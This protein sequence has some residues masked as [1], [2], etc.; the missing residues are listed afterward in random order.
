[1]QQSDQQQHQQHSLQ[2]NTSTSNNTLPQL[3]FDSELQNLAEMGD[4]VDLP[5]VF[6][7]YGDISCMNN[8]EDGSVTPS[9]LDGKQKSSPL[10]DPAAS[11]NGSEQQQQDPASTNN[12]N[13]GSGMQPNPNSGN[14]SASGVDMASMNSYLQ[15][16]GQQPL[17]NNLG[18]FPQFLLNNPNMQSLFAPIKP[19]QTQQ[20][21][22]PNQQQQQQAMQQQQQQQAQSQAQAQQ[23]A[24][25]VN[26]LPRT[27]SNVANGNNQRN[28]NVNAIVNVNA[29][30]SPG[31]NRQQQPTQQQQVQVQQQQQAQ[32]QQAQQQQQQQLQNQM[33]GLPQT[34][35]NPQQLA[36]A[37][38]SNNTQ[39]QNFNTFLQQQMQAQ[40]N[41][42]LQQ[43]LFSNGGL[44]AGN[45][46]ML[47]PHQQMMQ[48]QQ[49]QQ[50]QG[51]QQQ[52]QQTQQQTGQQQAKGSAQSQQEQSQQQQSQQQMYQNQILPL[53]QGGNQV[54]P[55]SG[56]RLQNTSS[57]GMDKP[58]P[59]SKP[60][61]RKKT[62]N[63]KQSY[64]KIPVPMSS[65][66]PTNKRLKANA[67]VS[68]SDTD[69]EHGA[70]KAVAAQPKKPRRPAAATSTPSRSIRAGSIGSIESYELGPAHAGDLYDSSSFSDLKRNEDDMTE[71]ERQLANRKRNREHA[72]NTRAR[73]KAY[74][75]S[76][77]TTL[78]ELC[79][80]RDSLV[81][82]RAGAATLLVEVQKTRMDVLLSFFALRS[83]YEKRRALWSSIMDESF[84]C[85]MPVTPYRS[86]PA[87]EVQISKCQR[88][89]LGVDG[90]MGDTASMHVLLNSL[91]DRSRFPHGK[92]EFR[93][94]LI[95]E[96]AIISGSQM[97]ARWNMTTTNA[98]ALGAK[99]EVKKMG[100]LC[101]RFNSVHKIVALELMF[102]VM[103]FML[104]LKQNTGANA[105]AVVPNTVQTC[106]GPFGNSPMVMTLADRPYTIVQVN[107]Q[108]EEMTGWKAEDVVGKE[109]CKILQG[110]K[111]EHKPVEDLMSSIRYQRPAFSVLT[112]YTRGRGKMFRNFINLY[113]LSTDSKITHYVGLTVHIEWMEGIRKEQK[114]IDHVSTLKGSGITLVEGTE[115]ASCRSGSDSVEAA[116]VSAS[117][118]GFGSNDSGSSDGIAHRQQMDIE[119]ISP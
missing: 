69:G 1:M 71:D 26:I 30:Q 82:E 7:D 72:R 88:T 68:C 16:Y 96:E 47:P 114:Q 109:S 52:Q 119:E 63:Q 95:A 44:M 42:Q 85:V 77:K 33:F 101:A 117:S 65:S 32:Q 5:E 86:F 19:A 102:D 34:G 80:E 87:S 100:M 21:T 110:E 62:V 14:A 106:V 3:N 57:A 40:G 75:E 23:L 36:A 46:Q 113:P 9:I 105:L 73:K 61:P 20:N 25:A 48:P 13:N 94:T 89:V 107:S 38:Q 11:A 35:F 108:W 79:R 4:D 115:S 74:V 111:T 99:R 41:A 22:N 67:V 66:V 27:N 29:N 90:M 112:N 56:G 50:L 92:V 103:A 116:K 59:V 18:G 60:P 118:S 6:W 81:S 97:M 70:F 15:T 45:N 93:Y 54:I 64:S 31:N 2:M 53:A 83:S 17:V 24:N 98:V 76:L 78:D 12:R 39:V 58:A 51:M 8:S 91:V 49:Q 43:Q 10:D 55:Q 28:V 84:T 37:W 104:Q